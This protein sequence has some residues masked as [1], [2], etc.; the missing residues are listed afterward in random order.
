M[1]WASFEP[2]VNRF[3]ILNK[4]DRFCFYIFCA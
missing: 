2:A 4:N 3:I 1:V